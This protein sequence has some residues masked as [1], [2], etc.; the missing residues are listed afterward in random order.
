MDILQ[1]KQTLESKK[2]FKEVQCLGLTAFSEQLAGEIVV[3]FLG[4]T[5]FYNIS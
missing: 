2:S 4:P 1:P 5:L 3:V